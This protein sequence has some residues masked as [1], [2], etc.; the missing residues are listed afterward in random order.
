M[1]RGFL[2]YKLNSKSGK[3]ISAT[4]SNVCKIIMFVLLLIGNLILNADCHVQ[5]ALQN[6]KRLRVMKELE[7]MHACVKLGRS[8]NFLEPQFIHLKNCQT[9]IVEGQVAIF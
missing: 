9:S 7:V 3:G 6:C 2:L 8:L 5:Y 4:N 1:L